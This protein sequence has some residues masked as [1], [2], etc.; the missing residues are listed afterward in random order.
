MFQLVAIAYVG[1]IVFQFLFKD[2]AWEELSKERDELRARME[3][4]ATQCVSLC[5]TNKSL[6]AD[7][8]ERRDEMHTLHLEVGKESKK[9]KKS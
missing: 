7:L 9:T 6:E 8:A 1:C 5:H 4:R 2:K 3:D